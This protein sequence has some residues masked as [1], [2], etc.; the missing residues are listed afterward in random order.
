MDKGPLRVLL[1]EDDP[2][3]YFLTSELLGDIPGNKIALEWAKTFDEGVAALDRC[4]HDAILLDYRLGKKDGLGLL[5]E[6]FHRSC[7]APIILLTGEGDR[8]LAL[9]ALEAG[10][11]D[12]LVKGDINSV[13]LERSIRYA[14]QQKSHALELQRKVAERTA[15]LEQVNSA[16]R[17][18]EKQIRALF[19]TAEA[20]RLSAEVAKSRAE[21]ATRA[22]DDFLAALSHELRTPLNPALL[23]ATS[24]AEDTTLSAAIRADIDVIAKGIAL[25]A[26]LVDDL[27]DITRITGGKLRLDLRPIDAHAALRHAHNILRA[28]IQE[29]EIDFSLHLDAPKQTIKA[30]AVRLQQIFWN[31]LKNAVKFTSRGGSVTVRTA[32]PVAQSDVLEVV[33][34]DSGVGIAPEMLGKIFDAFIQEDNRHGH[35]FGGIGLGLAITHRLVELQE[36]RI[37]VES[38]GRG[39]GAT[40]RI[41][42]PLET[43][44]S[45]A[46]AQPE[47]G[48]RPVPVQA[49]RHILLIEDHEQTRLT[50]L[51]LLQRR[52]HRVEGV[53]SIEAARAQAAAGHHDLVISDLGLPD[54][55]GHKL[56]AELH[57]EYG[58]AGIALS[59]YGMEHDIARSR[60]SGFFAH[61][62]KPI[63]MLALESAIAAAPHPLLAN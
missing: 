59:G 20:A 39:H 13:S 24:L 37:R 35:R 57:D 14:L 34:I 3:D 60:S 51:Q 48:D 52:G 27:L 29:R 61:L 56:M 12:Y 41:E 36:G 4:E 9:M 45:Q 18:S 30:D 2:D 28:D 42:L 47:P 5:R 8:D 63:N 21:E 7:N 31:V 26:Q 54:G 1:V 58:L 44:G 15:E 11:A 50:L 55:D 25:Q 62:T 43:S 16:L 38:K 19:E 10:A 32:N 53:A 33:V 6:A 40:F 17:E 46:D 49:S 22:K 23:L